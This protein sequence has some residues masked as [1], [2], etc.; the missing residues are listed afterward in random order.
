MQHPK[1]EG[2]AADVSLRDSR[3]ETGDTLHIDA[4]FEIGTLASIPAIQP[5]HNRRV[6]SNAMSFLQRARPS[7][8]WRKMEHRKLK[9]SHDGF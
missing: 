6:M 2:S 8:P 1:C 7:R 9:V 3:G 5:R 4:V